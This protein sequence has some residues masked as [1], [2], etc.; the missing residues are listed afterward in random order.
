A[1][2]NT[3]GSLRIATHSTFRPR[4]KTLRLLPGPPALPSSGLSCGMRPPVVS[5]RSV[6]SSVAPAAVYARKSTC[7]PGRGRHVLDQP[8]ALHGTGTALYSAPGRG[9]VFL[10]DH[11]GPGPRRTALR[12][13]SPRTRPPTRG[14]GA[15][16]PSRVR[17]GAAASETVG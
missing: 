1:T 17:L 14:G 9:G 5:R 11:G 2:P 15:P 10:P 4:R 12:G 16:R 7:H 13:S 6:G 8:T 3:A